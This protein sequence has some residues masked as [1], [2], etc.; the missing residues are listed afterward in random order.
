MNKRHWCLLALVVV[1]T[2]SG[3][4][5]YDLHLPPPPFFQFVTDMLMGIFLWEAIRP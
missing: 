3:T 2:V 1:G 4:V 5:V